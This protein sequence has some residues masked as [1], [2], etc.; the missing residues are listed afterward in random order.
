MGLGGGGGVGG[1]GEKKEPWFTLTREEGPSAAIA[2]HVQDTRERRSERKS[3][4]GDQTIA[5]RLDP[6][7]AFHREGEKV[8]S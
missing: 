6:S 2:K 3:S 1:G 7:V 8:Q 5:G 4:V